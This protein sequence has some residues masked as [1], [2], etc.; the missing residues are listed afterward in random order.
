MGINYLLFAENLSDLSDM[1]KLIKH[2]GVKRIIIIRPKIKE[3]YPPYY[4]QLVR[5][6]I[7]KMR[8]IYL[9]IEIRVDCEFSAL[10]NNISSFEL[11]KYGIFGCQARKDFL[12]L[13]PDSYLYP[14]C[15]LDK[16]MFKLEQDLESNYYRMLSYLDTMKKSI[17]DNCIQCKIIDN[18]FGCR[19][20]VRLTS[21]NITDSDPI[22]YEKCMVE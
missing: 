16:P 10:F 19:G 15:F 21:D 13:K 7:F 6:Q 3:K 11:S 2:L 17:E 4:P 5:E 18:C 9:S 14:C 8:E 1:A 12:I 22:C 20:I